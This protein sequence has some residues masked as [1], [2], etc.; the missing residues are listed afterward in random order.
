MKVIK[1]GNDQYIQCPDCGFLRNIKDMEMKCVIC[2]T[3]KMKYE[4]KQDYKGKREIR[5][6]KMKYLKN[7][8]KNFRKYACRK[9]KK[10]K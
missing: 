3:K 5:K 9:K 7:V 2:E 1:K 4:I 10:E 8:L 6:E